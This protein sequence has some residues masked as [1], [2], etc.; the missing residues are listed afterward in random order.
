MRNLDCRSGGDNLNVNFPKRTSCSQWCNFAKYSFQ[1]QFSPHFQ[2]Y[3]P[4][5]NWSLHSRLYSS[6][7]R[8]QL[9][10][11]TEINSFSSWI[12]VTR[13][14]TLFSDVRL[15]GLIHQGPVESYTVKRE[16]ERN[17]GITESQRGQDVC[18]H[19]CAQCW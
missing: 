19:I 17:S 5:L 16:T 11:V 13:H 8:Q 1:H 3:I 6:C 18:L 2:I 7:R 4:I 14:C 9:N 15:S 10:A 12:H